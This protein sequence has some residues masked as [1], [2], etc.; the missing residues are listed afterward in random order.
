MRLTALRIGVAAAVGS[1][2][3]AGCGP[4]SPSDR[5]AS[6]QD[7]AARVE[8]GPALSA[9]HAAWVSVSVATLWRSPRSPRPVDAPALAKPA[10]IGD[11]LADMTL[12]QRRALSGRADTQALLGS[13]V[14]VVRLRTHWAKVV[15]PSQPS[16]LDVRGYPGWVPRRQ[17]TA[18]HPT[19]AARWAIVL[20]RTAWLRT[21]R[22]KPTP[23]FRLSFGTRLPVVGLTH[24]FVRVVS[25]SG[26]VRRLA[27]SAVTVRA[28][29]EPARRPSRRSL[30]RIAKTFIGLPY[31]WSGT[32]GFGLDCSG[33]TWLTYRAHGITIPR[34]ASPQSTGGRAVDHPRR[35]DLM[36]YASDGLVHHVSM[37]V[38]DG[39]MIHA[40]GTGQRVQVVSTATLNDEFAG[41]RRYVR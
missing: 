21:D 4:G 38:G 10:R 29:G 30:V 28:D 36:F 34:D 35:A 39:R 14:R 13:R 41:A 37:Y 24:R 9:G 25:P 3:L 1:L 16:P 2:V 32:S 12:A 33:L 6:D 18:R 17:L 27:R 23:L 26:A 7:V 20:T 15:V 8:R 19:T 5:P 40:P 22:A 11:W 31:L